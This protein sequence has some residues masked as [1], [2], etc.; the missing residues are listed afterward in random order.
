M[1]NYYN[2]TQQMN[3]LEDAIERLTSAQLRLNELNSII[4][5]HWQAEEIK[6][7]SAAIQQRNTEINAIANEIATI[8]ENIRRTIVDIQNKEK[9]PN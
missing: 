1:L 6:Y 4:C 5:E 7:V 8:K 3:N 9:N 2:S